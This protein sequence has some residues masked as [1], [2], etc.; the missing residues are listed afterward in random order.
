MKQ[1][2]S[3]SDGTVR[4]RP[5]EARCGRRQSAVRSQPACHGSMFTAPAAGQAARSISARSTAIR[6]RQSAVSCSGRGVH[7]ASARRR[8]PRSW[9]C[10]RCRRRRT[11]ARPVVEEHLPWRSRSAG[12]HFDPVMP[13]SPTGAL[14]GHST[15]SSAVA[16]R[17]RGISM[18]TA[19]AVLRLIQKKRRS[20]LWEPSRA[21][22]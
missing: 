20:C 12:A 3:S 17:P 1:C 7:G 18:P 15:T 4:L 10:T 13:R 21:I 22:D 11:S 9:G 6:W 16:R 5:G 14:G 2:A 19:L 8:C